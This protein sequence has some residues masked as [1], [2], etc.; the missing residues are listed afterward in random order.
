MNGARGTV[1]VIGGALLAMSFANMAAEAV[2][3]EPIFSAGRTEKTPTDAPSGKWVLPV[4]QEVSTDY[5]ISGDVWASGR[6]TGIDFAVPTGTTVKSV[7]PGQVIKAGNGGSYGI[8]V[9]I[10]HTPGIYSQYAHL[11]KVSVSEGDQVES[12]QPIGKSGSTGNSTGPHLHFEIRKGP[13]YGDDIDPIAFLK[14][15]GAMK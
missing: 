10:K 7:G 1:F 4:N 9:V 6:H 14:D 15:Q 8:Q 11:S 3:G 13:N 12:G 5:N 2:T